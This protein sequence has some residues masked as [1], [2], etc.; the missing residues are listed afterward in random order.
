MCRVVLARPR[1][2]ALLVRTA[3]L[4]RPV[5]PARLRRKVPHASAPAGTRP[6]TRHARRMIAL[7]GC[8]QPTLSPATTSSAARVLDR[9]GISI[10]SAPQAGCCGALDFHLG[11]Q[12]AARARMRRNIDAWW[13]HVEAGAEA[14]I[15]TASGCGVM[16]KDYA[17]ELADDPDYAAKAARVSALARDVGEVLAQHAARLRE[18]LRSSS[19]GA[20]PRIAFHPPCTLQHGLRLR[21]TIEALLSELGFELAPVRDP[22]L[23]CGSAGTYSLLQPALAERLLANKI[24]ALTEHAP[25]AIVTANIGCEMHLRGA[26]AVPVRHWVELLDE[27]LRD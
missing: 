27:R 19:R 26:T 17:R 14:I 15:T 1:L 3:R 23:C 4:L 9:L 20:P 2:F 22:H 18:L 13:P 5:L 11:A 16:V 25:E 7:E 12:E 24:A 8:V 6:H 21:S 10:V